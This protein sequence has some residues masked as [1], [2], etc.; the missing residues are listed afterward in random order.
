MPV[1]LSVNQTTAPSDANGM[2]SLV[3][4][5]GSFT[6]ILEIEIQVS[7]GTTAVLQ[8][9][10]ETFPAANSGNTSPTS[11]LW[12]GTVPASKGPPARASGD[13]R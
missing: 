6:G 3:P 4:S 7:A 10:L 2:A 1:I 9:E 8:D 12:H 11:S 5:V 13:D